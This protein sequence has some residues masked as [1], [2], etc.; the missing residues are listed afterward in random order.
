MKH[1]FLIAKDLNHPNIVKYLYFSTNRLNNTCEFNIVLE[2][3]EGGNL[4][5]FIESNPFLLIKYYY[6]RY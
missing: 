3:L 1:E 5:E 2:Y 4:K 6:R